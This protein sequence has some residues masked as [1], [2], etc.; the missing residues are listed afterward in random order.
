MLEKYSVTPTI[1]AG[2]YAANDVIGGRL[3]FN[4]VS[5]GTI[6]TINIAD[7]GNQAANYTLL[8]FDTAPTNVADNAPFDV[9]DADIAMVFGKVYFDPSDA[10]VLTDNR[11]N[12][13]TDVGL[14]A[15]SAETTGDI[16]AFLYT[17]ST[18]SYSS[19]TDLV[20]TLWV[21]K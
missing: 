10:I 21:E 6:Q 12:I 11:I 19:T 1:T 14:R 20:I 16:W 7:K 5:F 17:T 3:Q 15:K 8:F 9:A 2:A 18:P 4:G 13:K